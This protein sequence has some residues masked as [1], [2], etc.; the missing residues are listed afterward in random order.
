MGAG[1]LNICPDFFM[2]INYETDREKKIHFASTS[3]GCWVNL[4]DLNNLRS[5]MSHTPWRVVDEPDGADVIVLFTCGAFEMP[6]N[7][8]LE[9]ILETK[10]RHPGS[11]VIIGGCLPDIDK[12]R[13]RAVHD[14]FL[15]GPKNMD[16]FFEHLDTG[17]KN[18]ETP[19][20]YSID[21]RDINKVL[22]KEVGFLH[23]LRRFL[24]RWKKHFAFTPQPLE[25][26]LRYAVPTDKM[27]CLRISTGCLGNC[28]YCAVRLAK[29]HLKSRPLDSLVEELE[30]VQKNKSYDTFVL[31]GD[32]IGCY[33]RDIGKDA[34]DLINELSA[35][36]G[37]FKLLI[38]HFNPK[39]L[40]ELYDRLSFAFDSGK[41]VAIWIPVQSGSNRILNLMNRDYDIGKVM[42]IVAKIRKNHPKIITGTHLINSFPTETFSEF[43]TTVSLVSKFD[44]VLN[45]PS[46]L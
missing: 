45:F 19:D 26:L 41:I 12:E 2:S 44:L 21:K 7:K 34:A 3:F 23:L 40:V 1:V 8:S 11:E 29:G 14:G 4:S 37:D 9:I 42:K 36:P 13:I 25:N 28:S 5:K 30:S 10:R 38:Y 18:H 16:A 15:F 32:D 39:W 24:N 33:G 31:V 43:L 22:R 17:V 6:I 27:Y 46:A 20:K 35:V